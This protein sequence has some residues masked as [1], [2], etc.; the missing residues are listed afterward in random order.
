MRTFLFIAFVVFLILFT[1][2]ALNTKELIEPITVRDYLLNEEG[3][4]E[5]TLKIWGTISDISFDF[6]SIRDLDFPENEITY[7]FNPEELSLS[8]Y[9]IGDNVLVKGI[10]DKN[11]SMMEGIDIK[12][13]EDDRALLLKNGPVLAIEILDHPNII[14]D[15]SEEIAITI[16]I[17]NTGD[18]PITHKDI[19]NEN[20]GYTIIYNLNGQNFA[21]Q[22]FEDFKIVEPNEIKNFEFLTDVA[23]NSQMKEG[24]NR[25]SFA[26]A[27]KSIYDEEFTHISKSN[28]VEIIFKK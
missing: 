27:K 6:F 14:F 11:H 20:F 15:K 17:E 10:Y 13:I 5:E 7:F 4:K 28:E 3:K 12:R 19:Y 22:V 2:F 24:T 16:Q 9:A 21:Y 23:I 1:S 8:S 26:W 18:I 25:I